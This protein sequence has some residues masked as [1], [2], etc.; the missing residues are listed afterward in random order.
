MPAQPL[1]A[2]PAGFPIR[3]GMLGVSGAVVRGAQ[4]SDACGLVVDDGGSVCVFV[5]RASGDAVRTGLPAVVAAAI[6]VAAR[7]RL[8]LYELVGD[9][10]RTAGSGDGTGA[11]LGLSLL[12]FSARDARVELLNAGMPAIVRLLPGTPPML[13]PSRSG[14]IGAGFGEVH[15]YELGPLVWGSAW[16]LTSDGVTGG[17][18]DPARLL[19][20]VAATGLEQ[21]A[22]E[23]AEAETA[24]VAAAATALSSQ[25]GGSI[26]ADRTLL[27]VNADPG[28]RPASGIES[29]A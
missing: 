20:G 9:V 19:R 6:G 23:L 21:S 25:S 18:L 3:V 26:A 10:R 15:P 12:R 11:Q 29:R 13:Y 17:S 16:L 24:R 14:S 2:D 7:A 1:E 28:R 4:E 27:V 5:V 8:P 22:P